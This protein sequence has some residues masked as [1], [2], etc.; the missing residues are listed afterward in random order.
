M[1]TFNNTGIIS[2]MTSGRIISIFLGECM[3]LSLCVCGCEKADSVD[4]LERG[5]KTLTKVTVS[6]GELEFIRQSV[7]VHT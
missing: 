1:S 2:F 6:L 7:Y 4:E 3:S 5:E